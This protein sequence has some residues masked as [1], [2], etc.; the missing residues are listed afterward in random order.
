MLAAL[1]PLLVA[2]ATADGAAAYFPTKPGTSWTYSEDAGRSHHVFTDKVGKPAKLLEVDVVPFTSVADGRESEPT[3]YVVD[4]DS[5]FVIF[6][7][8]EKTESN[9]E[10]VRTPKTYRYP[11]V[12]VAGKPVSWEHFG[13]TEFMQTSVDMSLKG[14]SRPIGKRKVLGR[15]VECVQ[16]DL[17]VM[18]G[19]PGEP[20]VKS[21]QRSVYGKGIGLVEM[22]ETTTVGKQKYSKKR[23]LVGMDEP[24]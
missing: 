14:S 15:E 1:L 12:K 18:F 4:G 6:K 24:Q 11:I 5:V 23:N 21:N 13:K 19:A 3:F 17:D 10:V 8:V 7:T 16:V 20:P 2:T 9:G 22:V